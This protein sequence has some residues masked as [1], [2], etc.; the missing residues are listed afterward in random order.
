MQIIDLFSGVGGFSIA[1]DWMG[2]ETVLFCEIDPFCQRILKTHYPDVPI[3]KDIKTITEEA[4]TKN[5]LYDKNKRTIL[6][7]GFPCQPFSTAGARKG[8]EDDRHLWPEML[9][10]IRLFQPDWV[11]AENVY[12]IVNWGSGLVFEQVSLDLEKE[13]YEVF[14]YILPACA[15]NAPHRRDRVW[16]VAHSIR[17]GYGGL[18]EASRNNISR[19]I[20]EMVQEGRWKWGDVGGKVERCSQ[21]TSNTN[22]SRCKERWPKWFTSRQPSQD[23]GLTSKPGIC[24]GD[25]GFSYRVD[26]LRVLGNAI[27]P[28]VVLQI[29][30]IINELND[31]FFY[32]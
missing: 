1:G 24:R 9:R 15:V 31:R 22:I 26:R 20:R 12:G 23:Y 27:V 7:G 13:G 11:V 16:F 30:K 19:E 28:Q 10:T 21:I 5:K 3:H 2:W 6:T 4:L 17:S 14:S 18:T 29:Y 32:K 25:D 8:T